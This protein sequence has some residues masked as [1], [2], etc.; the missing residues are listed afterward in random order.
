[1]H[2]IAKELTL[3]DIEGTDLNEILNHIEILVN[4]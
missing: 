3:E 1:L 2:N 4:S